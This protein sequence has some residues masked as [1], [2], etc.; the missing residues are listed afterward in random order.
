M[1]SS[2]GLRISDLSPFLEDLVL[3]RFCI[4]FTY[5]FF[6]LLQNAKSIVTNPLL[7]GGVLSSKPNKTAT[8]TNDQMT[9]GGIGNF[10][11]VPLQNPNLPISL[12]QMP[13]SI[14]PNTTNVVTNNVPGALRK[15]I[16]LVRSLAIFI[17]SWLLIGYF[18]I[19]R[20]GIGAIY[21]YFLQLFTAIMFKLFKMNRSLMFKSL[22]CSTIVTWYLV[23]N[24]L[25][26]YIL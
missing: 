9:G 22:L 15:H 6:I 25:M 26:W 21:V 13:N 24:P 12:P 2:T 20:R 18:F 10:S 5:F 11:N 17:I 14:G 8:G 7:S 1:W 19:V 23:V 3:S 4:F 16:S